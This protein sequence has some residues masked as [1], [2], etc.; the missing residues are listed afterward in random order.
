MIKGTRH[1][2]QRVVPF[3]LT[4]AALVTG[5]FASTASAQQLA[6]GPFDRMVIR[7]VTLIDGTGGPP[8][9]PVDIVV[10]NDR[11]VQVE[12]AKQR[13]IADATSQ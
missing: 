4:L 8:T 1:N 13:A 9:W 12:E 7:G 2:V 3:T 5:A 6:Q 11:I 10:E